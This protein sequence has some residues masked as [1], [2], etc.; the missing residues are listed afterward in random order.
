MAI[1]TCAGNPATLAV[2]NTVNRDMH[3]MHRPTEE[4]GIGENCAARDIAIHARGHGIGHI[5][6]SIASNG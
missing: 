5:S 2:V 6:G 4:E 1:F 3:I